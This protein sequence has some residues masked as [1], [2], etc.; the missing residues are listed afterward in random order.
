MFSKA[1]C[2]PLSIGSDYFLLR[3]L[4]AEFLSEIGK[5]LEFSQISAGF[6]DRSFLI[7]LRCRLNLWVFLFHSILEVN[8]RK[9]GPTT[10]EENVASELLDPLILLHVSSMNSDNITNS[11][12]DGK[13]FKFLCE[14]H[15]RAVFNVSLFVKIGIRVG[16]LE[17]TDK[18]ISLE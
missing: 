1:L 13:I 4:K 5:R 12:A 11:L 17:L 16:N 8:G 2:Y 15:Q 7:S 9:K 18:F 10:I 3:A 14:E 6:C